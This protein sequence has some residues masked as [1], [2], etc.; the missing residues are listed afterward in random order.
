M[1]LT[2]TVRSITG[3]PTDLFDVTI[4]AGAIVMVMFGAANRDPAMFPEPAKLDLER[5]NSNRHLAFGYGI[6]SCIG[7]TL[8]TAELDIAIRRL[9]ERLGP[10]R[11]AADAPRPRSQPDVGVRRRA[12][13]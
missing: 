7:R 8:A 4:P 9:L 12:R 13:P 11:L 2:L 10:I 1:P 6:H 5:P 3:T